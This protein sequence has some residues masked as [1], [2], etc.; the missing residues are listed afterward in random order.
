MS[1]PDPRR[2]VSSIRPV[3]TDGPSILVVE[4]LPPPASVRW[5]AADHKEAS[6]FG[7]SGEFHCL[8][9][10]VLSKAS[11]VRFYAAII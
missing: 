2:G 3:I 4:T 8:F 9:N 10:R 6:D 5:K 1:G 11:D 7:P